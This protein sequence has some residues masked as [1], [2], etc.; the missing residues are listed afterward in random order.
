M[1]PFFPMVRREGATLVFL[2]SFAAF[3]FIPAWRD[4]EIGGM[5]VFGWLIAALMLISPTVTLVAFLRRR[6]DSR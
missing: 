2:I 3:A 6:A 1:K 5:A 4:L